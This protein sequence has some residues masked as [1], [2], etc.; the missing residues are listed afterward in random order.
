MTRRSPTL[1][2][3]FPPSEDDIR[4][5][6][7]D[8]LH[9]SAAVTRAYRRAEPIPPASAIWCALELADLVRAIKETPL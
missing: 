7:K 5:R 9:H 1:A 3:C 2:R 6:W 8:A 4:T